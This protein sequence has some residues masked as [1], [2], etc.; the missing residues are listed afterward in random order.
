MT[1]E[2]APH[3]RIG[4]PA[5]CAT[6]PA[7]FT[8]REETSAMRFQLT[9]SDRERFEAKVDRSGGPDACHPWTGCRNQS[10]HGRFRVGGRR[11][12]VELAH[13]VAW[14]LAGN[15]ITEDRPQV[16]HNCP[17]GDNPA[18]CNDR[19]LWAGTHAENMR[20]MARKDSG[21]ASNR[22]LPFG[23]NPRPSGRFGAHVRSGGRLLHFGTY[24]TAEEASAVALTE[25]ERLCAGLINS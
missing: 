24:D 19:H 16:L 8:D 3:D 17:G 18:C 21:R 25:K 13:R 23:V 4:E 14:V 1:R 10:G 2:R 5:G 12:R 15:E 22:G 6:P 20:D 11:G 9:T 7:P